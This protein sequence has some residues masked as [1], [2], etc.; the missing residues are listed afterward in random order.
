MD[1]DHRH[2][3]K[4]DTPS[5]PN[6]KLLRN[7]LLTA[8]DDSLLSLVAVSASPSV[9]IEQPSSR[10]LPLA[11]LAKAPSPVEIFRPHA[12][13]GLPRLTRAVVS[14]IPL[15]SS[16]VDEPSHP[17]SFT[18]SPVSKAQEIAH[19]KALLVAKGAPESDL[20]MLHDLKQPGSCEWFTEQ[21]TFLSWRAGDGPS[22]F[23]L[24]GRP[25]AGKSVLASHVIDVLK[26]QAQ[27]QY[28]S[29]IIC[30]HSETDEF[31]LSDCL[32]SLAFQMAN[33]DARVREALM[34]LVH[35]DGLFWDK[36]D[37]SSV[38]R[39][40][41]LGCIFKL[42]PSALRQHAWVVDGI[43]E[44]AHFNGL[45]AKRF[46]ATLPSELR[47][48]ATSRQLDEI[49]RGI[50]ALGPK[51]ATFQVLSDANTFADMHLFVTARLAELGRPDSVDD[52][53]T[54]CQRILKKSSGSFLWTRLVLQEFE[55]AYTKEDMDYVLNEIPADLSTLYV[56]MVRS[57]EGDD[58]KLALAKSTLTWVTLASRPLDAEELRS[59]VKLD[60]SQTIQNPIR[61]IP[62]LCG[63]LVLVNQDGKVQ[64]I[65]ETV[66]EFLLNADGF[67]L[68]L[69]V[70][71]RAGHTRLGSILLRYLTRDALKLPLHAKTRFDE[72]KRARGF[73][74]TT[75]ITKAELPETSLL[76]Y[77]TRFFHEHLYRALAADVTLMSDLCVFL[78]SSNVL[79]WIE[80]IASTGDLTCI[81]QTAINMREY[82]R[83]RLKYV[84][85]LD[86]SMKHVDGWVTVCPLCFTSSPWRRIF[87]SSNL[88]STALS[89]SASKDITRPRHRHIS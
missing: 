24:A 89:I 39:R 3:C 45:F 44:C 74:T 69:K 5:N 43:D 14:G 35:N 10:P 78:K 12:S 20:E 48:F 87:G 57:V 52:R 28:C 85:P 25:A 73:M 54:M 70:D 84:P 8:I 49:E 18:R 36:T 42:E 76:D 7:A 71:K 46:L 67:G 16:A 17:T 47:L 61:L 27:W 66:R 72:S 64:L 4:F 55:T 11:E 60:I 41:F 86:P 83:R 32:R 79:S 26:R 56:R 50:S 19:L 62:D 22:V 81:N 21:T 77:A 75:R 51:K 40:L 68:E 59:A 80:R 23:W 31:T 13:Y 37:D 82:H 65:H 58:R 33:Q 29:Y 38:W 30:K 63:Q 9:T 34:E 2:V 6:Y 53:N 1:A 88:Y 15:P